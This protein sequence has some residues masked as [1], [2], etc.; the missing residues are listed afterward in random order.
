M[1]SYLN[2]WTMLK[3]VFFVVVDGIF[4]S[5]QFDF[6]YLW[7]CLGNQDLTYPKIKKIKKNI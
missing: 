6:D 1:T 5:L 4:Y 7:A 2:L 3:Y